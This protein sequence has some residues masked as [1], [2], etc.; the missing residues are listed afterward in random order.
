MKSP[1][2]TAFETILIV[3]ILLAVVLLPLT[4]EGRHANGPPSFADFDSNGDGFISEEELN[5]G[6]AARMAAM[7][8]A[9]HQL[10]GAASHPA[11]TDLDTDGDGRLNEDEFLAGRKAH[12]EKMH[13]Q[14]GGHGHG[15]GH[16]QGMKMPSFE[17]LDL[18]GDGCI[19]AEE[20]ADHQAKM[21]GKTR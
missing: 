6:R 18:D 4:V 12:M 11:F 10:K 16:G 2:K 17:D 13:G 5:A 15:K 14:K 21:H 19:N 3:T 20:F 8:E 1:D 9:G 7:A